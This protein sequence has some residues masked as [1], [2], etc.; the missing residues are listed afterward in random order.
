MLKMLIKAI[1]KSFED[2]AEKI[3]EF[4]FSEYIRMGVDF[5]LLHP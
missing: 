1:N 4:W 2:I 5:E 3:I